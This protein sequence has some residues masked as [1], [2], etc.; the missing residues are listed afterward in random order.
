[1][2]DALGEV[3]RLLDGDREGRSREPLRAS[4][5][6]TAIHQVN[7]MEP[8]QAWGAFSLLILL[9][10]VAVVLALVNMG[11]P[12]MVVVSLGMLVLLVY[13]YVLYKRYNV[14]VVPEADICLFTDTDDLRILCRI[15]GLDCSGGELG[16]RVR[17]SAF[18]EETRDRALA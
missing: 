18:V 10:D 6:R 9:A 13:G 8:K 2:A 11:Y 12:D 15:Y 17:L 3:G 16:L 5:P 4:Y 7:G 1:M 14:E